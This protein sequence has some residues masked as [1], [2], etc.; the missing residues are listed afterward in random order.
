MNVFYDPFGKKCKSIL[1]DATTENRIHSL[2]PAP[3]VVAPPVVDESSRTEI[4]PPKPDIGATEFDSLDGHYNRDRDYKRDNDDH[5][6]RSH[7]YDR[8]DKHRKHRKDDR[9][10]KH[11]FHRKSDRE[12]DRGDHHRSHRDR[13]RYPDDGRDSSRDSSKYRDVYKPKSDRDYAKSSGKNEVNFGSSGYTSSAAASYDQ[14]YSYQSMTSSYGSQPTIPPQSSTDYS[15]SSV[16]A[17]AT[18]SHQHP[19]Q[20]SIAPIPPDDPWSSRPNIPPPPAS[21]HVETEED[22]DNE[23]IETTKPA[24]TKKHER[25]NDKTGKKAADEDQSTID[26]DTRI[27]M[28]FN[29]KSFG[30]APPFLQMDDS[31][32]EIDHKEDGEIQ[33]DDTK[34]RTKVRAHRT[35]SK[36]HSS[37]SSDASKLRRKQNRLRTQVIILNRLVLTCASVFY[38]KSLVSGKT[39]GR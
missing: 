23:E 30:A 38:G 31:D 10:R 26:L 5:Y 12:R 3:P 18:W 32:P 24:V 17:S 27:A 14:A 19:W 28:M 20:S 25:D 21:N 11:P 7:S 34:A 37:K 1:D 36:S 22:W 4:P 16:P 2:P 39:A 8:R 6:M 35:R 9:E 29:Q 15:Y 13:Y 33:N